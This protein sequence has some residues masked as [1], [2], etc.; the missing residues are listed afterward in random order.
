V[1]RSRGSA[2]Q[3]LFRD[4]LS[5]FPQGLQPTERLIVEAGGGI[6]V[7]L[8]RVLTA[9]RLLGLQEELRSSD[10]PFAQRATRKETRPPWRTNSFPYF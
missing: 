4:P 7:S 1:S 8:A 2:L 9:H 6:P 5:R 10:W 3:A